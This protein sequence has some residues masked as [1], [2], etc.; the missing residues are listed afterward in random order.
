[1][2]RAG[3]LARAVLAAA[4]AVAVDVCAAEPPTRPVLRIDTAMHTALVRRLVVDWPRRRLVTAG[5]DKTIRIWRLPSGRLERVLR[6]PIAAGHEGKLFALAVSPDGRLIAAGGWTGWEWDGE[7]SLYVFD[8]DS[9]DM[10][11]RVSGFAEAIGAVGFSPDGRF[12]AVGLQTTGGLRVLRTADYATV[13]SDTEYRDKVMALDYAA[14]GRLAVVALDGYL[15]VY[16]SG[17]RLAARIRSVPGRLPSIV[18]FSPDARELAIGHAD[19]P[20]VTVLDAGEL[21]V[22]ATPDTR[23]LTAT[24][25]LSD[26]AWADDGS[27]YACGTATDG[28]GGYVFHWPD[29]GRGAARE[30][31]VADQR[32]T[33]LRAV[34]DGAVAYAAEDP[35]AGI[36]GRDGARRLDLRSDLAD[37]R[38]AGDALRVSSDGARV[39]FP[40]DVARRREARFSLRARELRPVGAPDA[41]LRPPIRASNRF[42]LELAAE[43]RQLVVNGASARLMDYEHV[44]SH[45]F[46]PDDATLVVG[47]DWNVRAFG[48]DGVERWQAATPGTAWNVAVTGDGRS[49]VATLS[50]GTIRWYRIEDGGEYLALFPHA[51][52]EEWIAWTPAGYYLSSNY[53]DN[54]V[55]WHLNRG[56]DRAP[57]FF[58]AVQFER[59]LYRPDLVDAAWRSRGAAVPAVRGPRFDVA[60]LDAIAPPALRIEASEADVRSGRVA[61]RITA[62]QRSLPMEEVAVFVNNIPILAGRARKLAGADRAGFV[63][64]VVVDLPER[65]NLVRVE[66]ANG[67]SLGLAEA[68]ID[69]GEGP[70]R[71]PRPGTLHVLAIGVNA[72]PGLAD[73]NLAYAARDASEVARV[74][75]EQRGDQFAAVRASVISDLAGGGPD[76]ARI[77]AAL[78]DF[79][80]NATADDT[81]VL[82]LASHGLSDDAGNYYFVPRDARAE[83]VD[84]VRRG[85]GGEASSLIGWRAFVDALRGAAGRRLLVVDTCRA[86]GI[87]GR[88]DLHS[89]AKRSASSRFALLVASQA[90]EDSQEYPPAGHGLFTH[91]LLEG[92]RGASDADG[93]GRLTLQEVFDYVVPLVERL[94]ARGVGP[95]TPQ[96]LAPAPLSATTLARTAPPRTSAGR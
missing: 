17:H 25:D 93:D 68:Y 95:Q 42:A 45:A 28:R 56:G 72:F 52:S 53:G 96:L 33:D 80:G 88:L 49:V 32:V 47:T 94:R 60:N 3:N 75:A 74:L 20:A 81:V 31:R 13:A 30:W 19:V 14:D 21:T 86:R 89:L 50:D 11:R 16:D 39:Q 55:G 40:Y 34:P 1:M 35:A 82:F 44:R 9:G 59:V 70:A 29:G 92:L 69:R 24:G 15:R 27:L 12:L 38:G 36:L 65:E 71:M 78:A 90:G 85:T 7:A 83:D 23:G 5:D 8:T 54:L 58:R 84:A 41:D 87:E 48:V 77:L 4:C 46:A 6:V 22:A 64:E 63:R 43:G 62:R 2:S 67:A 37:F 57:D 61:L 10:V 26:L 18:R 51:A 73:A 79:A 66:V 91:A 76:R